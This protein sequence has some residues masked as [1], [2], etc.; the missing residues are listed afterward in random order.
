MIQKDPI[1]DSGKKS[2]TGRMILIKENGI[3]STKDKIQGMLD[4]TKNEM[5]PVYLNG[6]LLTN[7]SFDEIRKNCF[8]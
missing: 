2:H 6:D 8:R 1:T 3:Y 7:V 4:D 5:R